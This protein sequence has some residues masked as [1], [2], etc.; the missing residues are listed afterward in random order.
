MKGSSLSPVLVSIILFLPLSPARA[1]P[2]WTRVLAGEI[3]AGPIASDDRAYVATTDRTVSCVS[4]DGSFLWNKPIPGKSSPFMTVLDSGIVVVVSGTGAVSAMSADGLFL[5]RVACGERPVA[6]PYEGRDG[7]IFLV[8]ANSVACLSRTARIKWTL[9]LPDEATAFVSETG[10]GDLLV[11]LSSNTL[12]RLSPFGFELSRIALD[13]KP[14]AILPVSQGFVCGY[15]SGR[16]VAYDV[17]DGRI[18]EKRNAIEAVWETRGKGAIVALALGEGTLC[19]LSASGGLTGLNET[20]GAQLWVA[21]TGRSAETGG[22][23]AWDY[24]LFS[25]SSRGYACAYTRDGQPVWELDAGTSSGIPVLSRSGIAY[26]AGGTQTLG[27]YRADARVR[28]EKRERKAENYG[29]LNGSSDEY[30]TPLAED[31]LLVSDFLSTVSGDIESGVTGPDEVSYSRRL[32]E[33]VLNRSGPVTGSRDFDA[34]ER[35]RAASLLGKLGSEEAR[36][37]LLEAIE[38]ERDST[39][40]VGILYGLA[41][42]GPD[43]DGR[44]LE[45]IERVARES[46]I[47]SQAVNRASCDALYAIVRYSGGEIARKGV[48]ILAG[49]AQSP[50]GNLDREYARRVM[51]RI[52]D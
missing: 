2:L 15:P 51:E 13:E 12:L 36:S 5:W 6:A 47:G 43:A 27:A 4:A 9:D 19:A 37:V 45:A 7:R 16:I 52:L 40:L 10:A 11:L 44:A 35:A 8:Y 23:V 29:I 18:G 30:G 42:L 50:Y 48:L 14:T 17:R 26:V 46:G 33:I 24:G 32:A 28:G 41:S 34:T 31:R 22:S 21:E 38:R 39:A 25:V 20:D 49:F 1:L 3:V